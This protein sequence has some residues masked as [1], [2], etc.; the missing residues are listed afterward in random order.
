LLF[1]QELQWYKSISASRGF[2]AFRTAGLKLL[3]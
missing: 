1:P 3:H 2:V